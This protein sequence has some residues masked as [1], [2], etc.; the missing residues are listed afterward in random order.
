MT[1]DIKCVVLLQYQRAGLHIWCR[2]LETAPELVRPTFCGGTKPRSLDHN[3]LKLS[4]SF[5]TSPNT[6]LLNSLGDRLWSS[7]GLLWI[8]TN[9][10][11]EISS[12]RELLQ[13]QYRVTDDFRF[14]S[15]LPQMSKQTLH[16]QSGAVVPAAAARHM[17]SRQLPH[18]P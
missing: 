9:D 10:R 1:D 8:K 4:N 17:C 16:F 2:L 6:K 15:M 12:L 11:L 7:V 13:Y 18:L 14:I 3:T 5:H